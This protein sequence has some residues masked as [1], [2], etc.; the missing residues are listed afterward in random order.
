MLRTGDRRW[1]P[2]SGL[3]ALVLA[4]AAALAF[5]AATA[6]AAP[7]DLD[8]TFSGDG[9]TRTDFSGGSD[10]AEGVAVQ[11]DGKTIAAGN[12]PNASAQGDFALARYKVNGGLDPT[13]S[14]DGK[15]R[16]DFDDSSEA[17]EEVALRPDG[18]IVAVGETS[19]G[20][21]NSR[22]AVVRY[23]ANGALDESFSGD[24]KTTTDFRP[25]SDVGESV[26]IQP[27]GK[28]VVVGVTQGQDFALA[29]YRPNGAPDD[30]FSGDEKRST[31][32][33]GGP[34]E[35]EGVAVQVDGKIVAAGVA[36]EAGNTNFA[37]A[38]YR[39]S[40]EFDVA[41]SGDRKRTTD[42]A[43][44]FDKL[45]DVAVQP[46][47]RIVG[48][49]FVQDGTGD[50]F[51]LVRY[52][53]NGAPDAT[54]SGDGKTRTDFAAGVDEAKGVVMQPNGKIIA[55]G[56]ADEAGNINFGLARYRTNGGL[57]PTFSGDGKV[58]TDF[59]GGADTGEDVALGP[60]GKIAVSGPAQAGAAPSDF[61]V[62]RY[63]GG[64]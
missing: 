59:A 25:G 12:G 45:E 48:A 29:R 13:F 31:D 5:F 34:D 37:V 15:T 42:Y 4:F 19:D 41:F 33:A 1:A 46:D 17:V 21:G 2:L 51:A 9:K 61:G 63:L 8:P 22:F 53:A 56:V 55:V 58:T 38:R 62:A 64:G 36:E 43:G 7:A 30:T 52:Q 20:S 10:E 54:F 14:G 11:P 26:A 49:G 23:K 57:D 32:F 27:D 47:G 6:I 39:P 50:D 60:D 24:G 18:K 40:G 44:G 35:A 28:I 16:T 3:C